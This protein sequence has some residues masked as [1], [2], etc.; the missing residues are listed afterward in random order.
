DATDGPRTVTVTATDRQGETTTVSL[1]ILVDRDLPVITGATP[2][3]L[4]KVK[5]TVTVGATG[6]ADTWG[7]AYAA[8]YAD[9][10]L[11]GKDTTAPYAVKYNSAKRNGTVKLEWRVFDK[12]GNSA[13]HR[14]SLIAD[15]TA[16]KISIT[17]GPKNKAKVKGTVKLKVSATDYYGVN[18][19]ELLINGSTVATDE[20]SPYA[21]S[22]KVADYP[23][24]M[25]VQVRAYDS[26]GNVK[27]APTRTWTR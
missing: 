21:F 17:S 26:V 7:V 5:G 16:P 1:P 20:T 4:T 19:V 23:K 24:K 3:H 18:R 12:A 2:A 14:L 27:Y 22:I 15:N 11:V 25:K 6:V 13:V 8:L 9:G 10:K